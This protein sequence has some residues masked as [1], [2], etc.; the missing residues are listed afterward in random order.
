MNKTG[1]NVPN[2]SKALIWTH[3]T[4][5]YL[6]QMVAVKMFGTMNGNVISGVIRT[7]LTFLFWGESDILA[8]SISFDISRTCIYIST[9]SIFISKYFISNHFSLKFLVKLTNSQAIFSLKFLKLK[10]TSLKNSETKQMYM[11]EPEFP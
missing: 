5:M 2:I 1:M 6:V 7:T 3:M 11:I 8:F 4:C 10:A 9:F